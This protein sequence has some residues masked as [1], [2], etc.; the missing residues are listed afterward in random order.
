MMDDENGDWD[1]YWS[2]VSGTTPEQL[3]KL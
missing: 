2:D 1:I 3:A